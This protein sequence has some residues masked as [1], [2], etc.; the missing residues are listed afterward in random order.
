[1]DKVEY[2]DSFGLVPPN[3]VIKYVKT[4]NKNIIYNDLQIQ[5][6]NSILCGYYCIYYIKKQNE[7]R[8]AD[9]VLLDFHD[10]PT[11]FNEK[12]MK[13]YVDIL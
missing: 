9:E 8:T 6:M 12:F 1:M 3:E 7:G 13:F 4:T 5:N 11:E 2:F 10:K